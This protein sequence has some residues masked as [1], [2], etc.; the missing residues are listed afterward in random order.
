MNGPSP[1]TTPPRGG[2]VSDGTVNEWAQLKSVVA[3]RNWERICELLD[4]NNFIDWVLINR[5]AGNNDL[6]YDT[7]WRAAG[8]GAQHRP[9]RFY[10]W[11]A[12]HVLEGINEQITESR[13]LDPTSLLSYLD[14]IEEFRIRF[15][16]RV[17]KHLFN[18]GV[19]TPQRNI[20]SWLERTDELSLAIIAES[21][22]WGDYRRDVHS[23]SSGPYN[24]YTRNDFWIPEKNRLINN[25]F[26][27]R[28]D[29]TIN[30]LRS[31]GL[32]PNIDAPQFRINGSYKHGGRIAPNA[33][34]TMSA[35]GTILYTLDGT[36][37]RLPGG[38]INHSHAKLYS[39]PITLALSTHVKTRVRVF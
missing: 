10:S 34:L 27:R 30:Q 9:W 35:T 8:G 11:D 38:T 15:G 5:F 16:D 1:H 21:A 33:R 26:P 12:E 20:Q 4:V 14:D 2:R 23:Y 19:L 39:G 32:Y 22:R 18:N 3:D 25:Y 28:T 6:K 36:D 29:I 17:H 37:T 13:D 7:N 24:L 31:H